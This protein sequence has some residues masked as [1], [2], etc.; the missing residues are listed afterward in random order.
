MAFALVMRPLGAPDLLL[1]LLRNG[2]TAVTRILDDTGMNTD[3]FY[4]A[5]HKL[6]ELGYAYRDEEPGHPKYKYTGLTRAGEAAAQALA[7]AEALF[8]GTLDVWNA[9][10]ARLEERDEPA[11]LPRRV[12]ILK[13]LADRAFSLG[14]WDEARRA[15]ERLI[16]LGARA[17]DRRGEAEGHLLLGRIAQKQD[18]HDEAL[19]ALA[20][21]L[22]LAEATRAEDVAS[23]AEYLTG[24]A[25]ERQSRWPEA[26][27]RYKSAHDRAGRAHD[28]LRVARANEGRARILAQQGH[29]D[30]ALAL[31]QAQVTEFERLGAREDLARAYGGLGATAYTANRPDALA[32]FEK[33]IEAA[34]REASVRMEAYGAANAAAPLTAAGEYRKAET[35][36]RRAKEVFKDLGERRGSGAAELALA[37]LRASQRKWSDAEDAFDEALRVA[38]EIG[39][40]SLEASVLM[41]RGQMLKGRDR[42]GEARGLLTEAKRIFAELGNAA[43]VARCEEEIRDLTG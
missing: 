19:A 26:L 32:W 20:R 5:L 22:S 27:E 4:D 30:E 34:L 24:S 40:R 37:N 28:V 31:Y 39:Y 3:T 23:D 41:N 33:S 17:E 1:Y 16:E 7:P 2:R 11:T 29:L 15:A 6:V 35:Y 36:L 12:E 10:L 13:L 25:M 18:R 9:E 14:R 8:K 42:A 21:A 43:R 38:R